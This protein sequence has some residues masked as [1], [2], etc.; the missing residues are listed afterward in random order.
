LSLVF[1]CCYGCV[2]R[3]ILQGSEVYDMAVF[4]FAKDNAVV[5]ARPVPG[6]LRQYMIVGKSRWAETFELIRECQSALEI[7]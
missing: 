7:P 4:C 5:C 1:G 2:K 3:P 6:D